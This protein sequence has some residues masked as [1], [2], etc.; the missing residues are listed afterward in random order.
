VTVYYKT[1]SFSEDYNYL[2]W[3]Q[4]EHKTCSKFLQTKQQVK[5]QAGRRLGSHA[6]TVKL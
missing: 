3:H 6:P 2:S 5:R 4:H 1:Y